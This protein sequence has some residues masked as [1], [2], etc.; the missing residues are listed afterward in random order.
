MPQPFPLVRPRALQRGDRVALIAPSSRYDVEALGR[1]IAML[2]EWGLRV[3]TQPA[4]STVRYL[5]APDDAR[6]EFLNDA[7]ARDDIAAI[8][9]IRGGYG[10]SRLLGRFDAAA[11]RA[12]PKLFIGYSDL[13]L[14]L[15]RLYAE[16]GLVCF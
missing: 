9:G 3:E 5:A 6:A 8:I 7:F 15:C 14:L 1:G 4:A 12:H 16:A 13:T 2:E 11:A 10:A